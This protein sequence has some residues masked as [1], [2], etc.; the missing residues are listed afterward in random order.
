MK[1]TEVKKKDSSIRLKDED[2][3]KKEK[4]N[5][6]KKG[7]RIN[8]R[9][10]IERSSF[11]DSTNYR[12]IQEPTSAESISKLPPIY[13]LQTASLAVSFALCVSTLLLHLTV[14]MR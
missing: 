12:N 8:K 13:P 4:Q 3:V 7:G 14:P 1:E 10:D 9:T 11:S 6:K 5:K 2:E